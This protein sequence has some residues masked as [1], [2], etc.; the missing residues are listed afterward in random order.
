MKK[1]GILIL[2]G[3]MFIFNGCLNDDG[4]SLGDQ[5]I[6]FGVVQNTDNLWIKM[7]DGDLLKAISYNNSA[8]SSFNTRDGL[9]SGDRVFVNFTILDD[10]TNDSTNVTTYMVQINS[11]EEI[12]LKQILDITSENEDSIGNDPIV[13]QDAWVAN[14]MV[15]F[16]LKYLG[17]TKTHFINLVKQPGE[18][19]AVDQPFQLELRHNSNDDLESI[20]YTAY[21]SFHLDSLMM[22]G[23][24][25]VK[26]DVTCEDYD[27]NPFLYE[28]TYVYGESN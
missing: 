15:N 12:L 18:L 8:Y 24:D 26:F 5:W 11:L 14:D 6:G 16:K 4:Y 10:S 25:S 28:G 20:P 2:L 17:A 23:L 21:V 22:A 19:T 13:V 1:I 7:D 3:F 9:D 27:G